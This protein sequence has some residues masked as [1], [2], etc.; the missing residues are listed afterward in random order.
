[1]IE[2]KAQGGH[3]MLF[4]WAGLSLMKGLSPGAQQGASC[5]WGGGAVNG[6]A[7]AGRGTGALLWPLPEKHTA[8]PG[9]SSH[10]GSPAGWPG[11][12]GNSS[13]EVGKHRD[14]QEVDEVL[15]VVTCR[16]GLPRGRFHVQR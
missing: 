15:L 10:Q 14:C 9:F 2:D 4:G 1:M 6:I 8:H 11:S 13:W 3:V 12:W 7:V 16:C 5:S